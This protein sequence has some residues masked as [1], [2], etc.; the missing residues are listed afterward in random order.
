[1]VKGYSQRCGIDYD[2]DYAP[3]ARIEST[4]IFIALAAQGRWEIHHIDVKYAFLIG[5]IKEEIFV[6]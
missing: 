1:M 2:E 6:K 3:I 5:D 4:T